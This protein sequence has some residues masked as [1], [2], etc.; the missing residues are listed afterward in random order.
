MHEHAVAFIT[1]KRFYRQL[2]KFRTPNKIPHGSS[3]EIETNNELCDPSESVKP[4]CD[5]QSATPSRVRERD[6]LLPASALG[7]VHVRTRLSEF[8]AYKQQPQGEIRDN[9][10]K[11]DQQET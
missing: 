8:G 1:K 3:K 5:Q 6:L 7:D 4:A 10:S 11:D 9:C 2:N